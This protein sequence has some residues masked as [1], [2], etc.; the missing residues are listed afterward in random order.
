[1]MED[2]RIQPVMVEGQAY[3][4]VLV[5]EQGAWLGTVT[6]GPDASGR[7]VTDV[8]RGVDRNGK[9]LPAPGTWRELVLEQLIP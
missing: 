2:Y 5:D 1:M 9:Y 8:E 7:V 3:D 4:G 6:T